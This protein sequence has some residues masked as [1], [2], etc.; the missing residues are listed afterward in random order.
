MR[1]H[2]SPIDNGAMWGAWG[3]ALVCG[4]LAQCTETLK[5]AREGGVVECCKLL[6]NKLFISFAVDIITR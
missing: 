6:M 2:D 4:K 3:S 5:G 1:Q